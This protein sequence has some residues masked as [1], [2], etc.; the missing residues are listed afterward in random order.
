MLAKRI[1]LRLRHGRCEPLENGLAFT[2]RRQAVVKSW[3]GSWFLQMRSPCG[4]RLRGRGLSSKFVHKYFRPRSRPI[5]RPAPKGGTSIGS[6]FATESN[7]GE[8]SDVILVEGAGG[9]M[10]PIS[11]DDYNADLAAEFGFPLLVVAANELGTI[12]ATLQTLVTAETF[13]NGLS[14]AGVVLNSPNRRDDDESVNSNADEL[15]RRSS[16]LYWPL[17]Q[18]A[19]ASI[20][21]SIGQHC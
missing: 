11:D 13:G 1:L 8:R 14:V 5:W 18:M 6:N 12:N 17:W 10:S 4:R 3:K 20:A 7:S 9:L 21:Q 19:A 15:A 16:A 2:S